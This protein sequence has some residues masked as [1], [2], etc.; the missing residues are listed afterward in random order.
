M[1]V[2]FVGFVYSL[3]AIL[4]DTRIKPRWLSFTLGVICFFALG[5]VCI[6]MI[7]HEEYMPIKMV[8][9]WFH[10]AAESK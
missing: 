4:R 1:V 10:P 2:L 3:D 5:T 6:I 9:K 8:E 7:G